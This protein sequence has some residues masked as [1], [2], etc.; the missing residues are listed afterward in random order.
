MFWGLLI[1]SGYEMIRRSMRMSYGGPTEALKD[2][3][4]IA[5]D[6]F[7]YLQPT[8]IWATLLVGGIGLGLIAEI[9]KRRW[10]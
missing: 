5:I 8:E 4:A 7:V 3:V 6:Y 9:V 10:P 1:F 2:Q